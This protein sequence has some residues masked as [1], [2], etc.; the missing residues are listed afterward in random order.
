[1]IDVSNNYFV[2]GRASKEGKVSSQ[3]WIMN[4]KKQRAWSDIDL[5]GHITPISLSIIVYSQNWGAGF[6][7]QTQSKWNF[8]WNR[9]S[10]ATT[11]KNTWQKT[12]EYANINKYLWNNTS[13]VVHTYVYSMW[14]GLIITHPKCYQHHHQPIR[15]PLPPSPAFDSG[16][17]M[18]E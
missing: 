8:S 5:P 3:Y 13:Y 6:S 4:N 1:M 7:L 15:S 16:I 10:T 14:H 11:T 12:S 17:C 2:F 9:N 18:F